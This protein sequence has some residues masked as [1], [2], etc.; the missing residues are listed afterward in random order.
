MNAARSPLAP[1]TTLWVIPVADLGGV[2]RHVLDVAGQGIPGWRLI[3]VCPDGPLADRLRTLGA[4]VVTARVS[5][6]DGIP[7]GVRELRRLIRTVRPAVVHSHLSYADLLAAIATVG[8]ETSLV[9]TEHG[10]ARDDLVYHGTIWRSRLKALAH[11]A[12]LRRADA[13]IAVSQ[14]TKQVVQEK[15]HPG[16]AT[17][18]VVIHNGIDRLSPAV[19][20]A[21]GL[22]VASLA[23]LAPEKGLKDLIAAFALL[24]R[25]HPD[26]RLTIAGAGPLASELHARADRLGVGSRVAFPGHIEP[27][28]LL[29]ESDVLAQL[30]V[31]ENTSYSILD[32]IVYG[33]GVVA[34]PVGGNPEILG[35]DCLVERHDHAAVAAK[36]AIQ[37]RDLA[38]RPPLPDAWPTIA[39]M[40]QGIAETYQRAALP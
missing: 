40:C 31:W 3:V 5:P 4:A 19:A 21:P 25:D 12:R 11:T 1:P 30:S 34:T 17:R 23:R 37:G 18:L 32:A 16:R 8:H 14:S 24:V 13:L 7:A 15:W 35:P 10:I 22:H 27:T 9:T 6:A 39:E 33:L 38:R 28:D 36:I 29:A 2:A 20:R 26:A